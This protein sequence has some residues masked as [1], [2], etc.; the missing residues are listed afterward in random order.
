MPKLKYIIK[1]ENGFIC[2]DKN[3]ID[4]IR[5]VDENS[6]IEVLEDYLVIN[7]KRL[8]KGHTH[9]ACPSPMVST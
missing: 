6:Y 9:M 8:K 7:L 3:I 4:T 2:F 5:F 1:Q